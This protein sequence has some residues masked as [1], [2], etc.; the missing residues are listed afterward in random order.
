MAAVGIVPI[1]VERVDTD[2]RYNHV[3]TI[4]T[5]VFVE[6]EAI[7]QD[8][9]YDGFDHLA[10]HYLAWYGSDPAGTARW[11]RLTDG[12]FR[13]ERFAVL[14]PFRQKGVGTALMQTMLAELPHDH[15][16]FVHA[17]VKNLDFYQKLGF[18]VQGDPFEEA[19][20]LHVKMQYQEPG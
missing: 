2:E 10:T 18:I 17:Q 4:R 11:R 19:G 8:D 5:T 13:L 14:R 3:F 16:I 6:E 9:E 12:N 1:H 20:I 7:D 15:A